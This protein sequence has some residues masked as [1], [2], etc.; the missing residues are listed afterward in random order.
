MFRLCKQREIPF[1]L[2]YK[3]IDE[4]FDRVKKLQQRA[5]QAH[6]GNPTPPSGSGMLQW[7]QKIFGG[8][9]RAASQLAKASERDI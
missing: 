4:Q 6:A 3:W 8:A 1:H 2:W 9:E 7:L 5:V